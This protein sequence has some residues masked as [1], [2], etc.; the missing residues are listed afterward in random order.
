MKRNYD[1]AIC[2]FCAL[3]ILHKPC[4]HYR[5]R[6]PSTVRKL[7]GLND[8]T[9][10]F[11]CLLRFF[12][13]SSF[14]LDLEHFDWAAIWHDYDLRFSPE[15]ISKCA[16]HC[17]W[18]VVIDCRW[19]EVFCLPYTKTKMVICIPNFKTFYF[20]DF[21][22]FFDS[23]AWVMLIHR[24]KSI[25]LRNFSAI[26]LICECRWCL[27]ARGGTTVCSLARCLQSKLW[28]SCEFSFVLQI[29]GNPKK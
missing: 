27:N 20:I 18:A 6:I 15:S 23:W 3:G 17:W 16:I 7:H 1:Y 5:A 28:N 19:V 22:L 8:W 21:A 24:K 9:C 26:Q 14:S 13:L 10:D 11:C 25:C 4:R 2:K 29:C 12:C